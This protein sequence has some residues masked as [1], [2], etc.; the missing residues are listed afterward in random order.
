MAPERLSTEHRAARLARLIAYVALGALA[1]A[2]TSAD[3]A[4]AEAAF[5]GALLGLVA[6]TAVDWLRARR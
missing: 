5:H 6:A 4:R 2:V 3:A 1:F